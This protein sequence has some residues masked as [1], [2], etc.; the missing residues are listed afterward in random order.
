MSDKVSKEER[1]DW[2][3][4][5]GMATLRPT[6]LLHPRIARIQ[7][8]TLVDDDVMYQCQKAGHSRCR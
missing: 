3:P 1:K 8:N 4:R 7:H 5:L 6:G 2:S